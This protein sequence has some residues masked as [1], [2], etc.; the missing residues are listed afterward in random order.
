[1]DEIRLNGKSLKF[2]ET[3][4]S[5]NTLFSVARDGTLTYAPELEQ[6]APPLWALAQRVEQLEATARECYAGWKRV[7]FWDPKS[8]ARLAALLTACPWLEER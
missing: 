1:M 5:A 8:K 3:N 6:A 2:R 4:S 7:S